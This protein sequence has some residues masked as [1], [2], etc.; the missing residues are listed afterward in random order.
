M[1]RV[2]HEKKTP[3]W[4]VDDDDIYIMTKLEQPGA[5]QPTHQQQPGEH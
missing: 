4:T 1:Y 5:A 2:C 3:T